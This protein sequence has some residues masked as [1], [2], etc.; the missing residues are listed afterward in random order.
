MQLIFG[1][2]QQEFELGHHFP[3]KLITKPWKMIDLKFIRWR[4]MAFVREDF[5]CGRQQPR[6]CKGNSECEL[7]TT[8]VT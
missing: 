4:S 7:S 5:C 8:Q 1:I 6:I 2:V 3:Y